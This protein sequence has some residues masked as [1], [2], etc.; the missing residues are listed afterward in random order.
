MSAKLHLRVEWNETFR[1]R[2][3]PFTPKKFS[4]L[5][6]DRMDRAHA[7]ISSKTKRAIRDTLWLLYETDFIVIG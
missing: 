1:I 3:D 7:L 2:P 5:S 6:P 4:N